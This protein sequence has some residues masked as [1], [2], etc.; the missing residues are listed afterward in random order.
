MA[1]WERVAG[2]EAWCPLGHADRSV[3]WNTVN[4]W[5]FY[6]EAWLTLKKKKFALLTLTTAAVTLLLCPCPNLVYLEIVI[7]GFSVHLRSYF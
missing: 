2:G 1:G 4:K 5:D 3:Y 7:T 6:F